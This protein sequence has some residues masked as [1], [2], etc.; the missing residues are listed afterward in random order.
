MTQK[1]THDMECPYYKIT[2]RGGKKTTY[3]DLFLT[4]I[5]WNTECK[6]CILDKPA[7]FRAWVEREHIIREHLLSRIPE[8][9][10]ATGVCPFLGDALRATLEKSECCGGT[11]KYLTKY[12]CIKYAKSVTEKDCLECRALAKQP[13]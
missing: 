13:N 9:W 1:Y 10:S 12:E 6:K 2:V 7:Q 4:D 11:V 5:D 3:C 8:K